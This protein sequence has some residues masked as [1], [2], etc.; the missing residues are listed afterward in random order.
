MMGNKKT[1]IKKKNKKNVSQRARKN[2]KIEKSCKTFIK[3]LLRKKSKVK[4]FPPY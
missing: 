2:Y 4:I 3:I 1:G